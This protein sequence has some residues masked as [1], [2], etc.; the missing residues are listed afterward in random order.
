MMMKMLRYLQQI[1]TND[2][3][4]AIFFGQFLRLMEG[5]GQRLITASDNL[6]DIYI[7]Q[8]LH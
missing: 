1:K 6:I 4:A 3:E 7:Y 8:K 2:D 5:M